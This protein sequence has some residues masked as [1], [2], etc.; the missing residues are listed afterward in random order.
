M[1]FFL[2]DS[3]SEFTLELSLTKES[4]LDLRRQLEK[5]QQGGHS[6]AISRR[7]AAEFSRLVPELLDWDIKRPTKAQIAYARS[8]CYRLKIEGSTPISRTVLKELQPSDP[9]WRPFAASLGY[10]VARCSQT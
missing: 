10:G 2:V 8:I 9:A 6:G 1:S 3:D 5:L 4:E 7:L